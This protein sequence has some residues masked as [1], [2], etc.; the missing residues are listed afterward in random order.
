MYVGEWNLFDDVSEFQKRVE[1][2][3]L[4]LNWMTIVFL[5]S[6]TTAEEKTIAM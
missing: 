3:G 6:T 4:A 2:D 5:E 1:E